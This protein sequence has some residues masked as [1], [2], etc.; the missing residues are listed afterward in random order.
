MD[1]LVF[2]A[3]EDVGDH[4]GGGEAEE[5]EVRCESADELH[6]GYNTQG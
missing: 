6:G 4:A 2:D 5:R 3:L 1:L